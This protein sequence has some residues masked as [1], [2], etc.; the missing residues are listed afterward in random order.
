M[1]TFTGRQALG[2][3][4]LALV[5][6]LDKRNSSLTKWPAQ[7]PKTPSRRRSGCPVNPLLPLTSSAVIPTRRLSCCNR[8]AS[9]EQA[10]GSDA[11][12]LRGQAYLR[13]KRGV[14]AAAEFQRFSITGAGIAFPYLYPLAQ[15]GL[16]RN[17]T[18]WRR[19][20]KKRSHKEHAKAFFALWKTP[21]RRSILL[22]AR[23]RYQRL[24]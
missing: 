22:K 9:M 15:L 1:E 17:G 3:L 13:L 16:A 20:G 24:K 2:S 19:G 8:S 6:K 10:R 21:A 18:Q 23:Q 14:E 4:T 7:I 5:A 11:I 12:Y